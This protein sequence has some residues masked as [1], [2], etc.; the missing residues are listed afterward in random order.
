MPQPLLV[1]CYI[2]PLMENNLL[3]FPLPHHFY[4]SEENVGSAEAVALIF[5]TKGTVSAI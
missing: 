3:F 1:S 5:T 4:P 2:R